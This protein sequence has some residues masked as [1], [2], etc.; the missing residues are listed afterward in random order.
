MKYCS[1]NV[2]VLTLVSHVCRKQLKCCLILLLHV[3]HSCLLVMVYFSC[4]FTELT[5]VHKFRLCHTFL[6]VDRYCRLIDIIAGQQDI[7]ADRHVVS[8]CYRFDVI[9]SRVGE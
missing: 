6:V 1:Y 5:F 3:L 4:Y 7:S 2:S 9:R 8:S